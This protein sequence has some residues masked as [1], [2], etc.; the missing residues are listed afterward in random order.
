MAHCPTCKCALWMCCTCMCVVG[1]VHVYMRVCYL[2]VV[3]LCPG[4]VVLAWC[5]VGSA[6]VYMSVL[7]TGGGAVSWM[8]CTCMVCCRFCT[9]IHECVTYWWWSCVL[10]VLYLHGVL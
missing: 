2:L 8:C 3:G 1:S 6:L 10:D 4:C 5:V 9:C 7:L